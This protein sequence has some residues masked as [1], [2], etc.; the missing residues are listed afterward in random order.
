MIHQWILDKNSRPW[1]RSWTE[2][3]PRRNKYTQW[4]TQVK[5][6]LILKEPQKVTAPNNYRPIMCLPIMHKILTVPIREE[7]YYL[8]ISCRLFPQEQKG[9]HKWTKGAVDILYTDLHIFKENK[10]RRKNVAIVW[11]DNKKANDRVL[12]N[13]MIDWL[14]MHIGQSQKIY[15]GSMKKYKVI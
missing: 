5:T 4:M 2:Q 12:E 14:K 9:Y 3:M 8:L 1:T 10:T 15:N 6:T 7:I 13:L 11:I